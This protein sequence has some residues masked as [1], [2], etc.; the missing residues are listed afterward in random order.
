[1]PQIIPNY[2]PFLV[3]FTLAPLLLACGLFLLSLLLSKDTDCHKKCLIVARWNLA[4]GL[5]FMIG[6]LFAGWLAYN[7]VVHDGPSHAAMTDHRNWAL[8]TAGFFLLIGVWTYI[9]RTTNK[10]GIFFALALVIGSALLL[11]T[12]Y[13]GAEAVYRHGLG[14]M[15]LPNFDMMVMPGGE[16]DEHKSHSH[17]GEDE[18]ATP[19]DDGPDIAP[20]RDDP[21]A[22]PHGH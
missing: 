9:T 6:T 15:S 16:K 1:M 13:K 8:L 19:H 12:G 18:S 20:H 3:H 4:I 14:V 10:I 7:S 21:E 2:H 17:G 22:T 5:L 11:T